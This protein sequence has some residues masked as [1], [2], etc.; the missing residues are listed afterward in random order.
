MGSEKAFIELAGKTLLARAMTLARSLTPDVKIVADPKKFRSH[1]D[2]VDDQYRN[3]GPLAGIHA[4]LN[5]SNSTHNLILGVDLPFLT[6]AFLEFL[7][8]EARASS[9]IVVVPYATAHFHPLCAVYRREFCVRAEQALI[10]GHN[11]ID[12]LFP[13]VNTRI[14]TEAELASHGFAP[15]IF[16]NLNTPA[17]L[18]QANREFLR[19]HL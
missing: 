13:G 10:A 19:L 14:I 3:R 7:A 12:S 6:S 8:G 4:A 9:A 1:G 2:V 5:A 18:E 17:D 15:A 11:R 16:R